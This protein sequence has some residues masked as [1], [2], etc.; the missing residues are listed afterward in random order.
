MH[1]A[2][3]ALGASGFLH[4]HGEA[5]VGGTL[6]ALS[7]LRHLHGGDQEQLRQVEAGDLRQGFLGRI[8]GSGQGHMGFQRLADA[9]FVPGGLQRAVD[10]G[11]EGEE[12][13]VL[14]HGGLIQGVGGEGLVHLV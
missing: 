5:G 4:G 13:V 1:P 9:L 8:V 12:H 11:A 14:L 6:D 7:A 2:P 10:V 3:G